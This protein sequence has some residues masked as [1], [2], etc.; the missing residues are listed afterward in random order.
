MLTGSAPVEEVE[1]SSNHRVMFDHEGV[2]SGMYN[3]TE[4]ANSSMIHSLYAR[5]SF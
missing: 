4:I 1:F 2:G 3:V 5:S